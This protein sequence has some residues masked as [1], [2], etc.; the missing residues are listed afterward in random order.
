MHPSRFVFGMKGHVIKLKS[1]DN[2][3]TGV[4]K[5]ELGI[6]TNAVSYDY[7]ARARI[8]RKTLLDGSDWE[9]STA[10]LIAKISPDKNQTKTDWSE[11][12]KK[13]R[14]REQGRSFER[15]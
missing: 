2:P 5:E 3:F 7:D 9:E 4:S 15:S 14:V 13:G 10:N 6:R 8:L 12:S 1:S 11:G